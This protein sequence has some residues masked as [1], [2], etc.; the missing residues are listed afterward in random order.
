MKKHQDFLSL[1]EEYYKII[2]MHKKYVAETIPRRTDPNPKDSVKRIHKAL[3]I[4]KP[5]LDIEV[6]FEEN[7]LYNNIVEEPCSLHG[8]THRNFDITQYSTDI[9]E[10]LDEIKLSLKRKLVKNS[11]ALLFSSER[12]T[13]F[14]SEKLRYPKLNSE[15]K[16]IIKELGQ[17]FPFGY[18]SNKE[19]PEIK[20]LNL[21]S[22]NK[23]EEIIVSLSSKGFSHEFI[24]AIRMSYQPRKIEEY[25]TIKQEKEI[26]QA[27]N[28]EISEEDKAYSLEILKVIGIEGDIATIISSKFSTEKI[29]ERYKKLEDLVG[30][31]LAEKLIHKN[32]EIALLDP[33][34]YSL[35]LRLL[36]NTL[37]KIRINEITDDE[38]NIEH[39]VKV[40]SSIPS[41]ENLLKKLKEEN[42]SIVE[43]QEFDDETEVEKIRITGQDLTTIKNVLKNVYDGERIV[44]E[45]S[46]IIKKYGLSFDMTGKQHI[47]LYG[48]FD[49]K[50]RIIKTFA[51]SP[52]D[53]RAG[54]P[55]FTE[56]KRRLK[57]E[58]YI[59]SN[60]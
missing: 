51:L 17:H 30:Y 12:E 6:K 49:G 50:K 33:P 15:E 60:D 55:A 54:R 38:Y 9:K 56:L 27:I 11:L 1:G 29:E 37:N 52:S 45:L 8:C 48:E 53:V 14:S 44:R 10:H 32:N 31:H 16:E 58:G 23:L 41:L 2:E 19:I 28:K 40:F 35:Y 7:W 34:E 59:L 39:N 13:I 46:P 43:E 26:K 22:Q 18:D 47:G 4:L 42:P 21:L 20:K 3:N 5:F 25:K 36:K 57:E 24:T